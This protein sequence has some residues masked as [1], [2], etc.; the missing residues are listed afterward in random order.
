M[1]FLAVAIFLVTLA[2]VVFRPG[3]IGIWAVGGAAIALATGVVSLANVGTVWSLVWNATF[4]F[5][6]L[7]LLSLVLDRAG[8]FKA[9]AVALVRNSNGSGR[10]LFLYLVAGCALVAAIFANDGA[11]LILT[12][13]VIEILTALEVPNAAELALVL[14][15]GF[16]A[17][18]T[19]LPLITSNLVN[20]IAANYSHI[21]Y[22]S[23]AAVMIPVDLVAAASSFIVLWLVFGKA[24]PK[25]LDVSRTPRPLS[26]VGDMLTFKAG[27]AAIPVLLAGYFV[28]D[29]FGIPLSVT[30]SVVTVGIGAI[31]LRSSMLSN[32]GKWKSLLA[33]LLREAPWQ[34]VIFSV[35]MYLVVYGL[36]NQGLAHL[37]GRG[38]TA[39]TSHGQLAG[40]L[41]AGFGSAFASSIMNNLPSV[42]V[43]SLSIT[44]AHVGKVLSTRLAYANI[45][46]C[47]L[48]PKFTPIGSLATLLWLHVLAKRSIDVSWRTYMSYGAVLT[49][50]VLTVVLLALYGVVVI[51]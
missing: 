19:S 45:I 9:I 28:G 23:Y 44:A 32:G 7:I 35:G 37:L 13:V 41:A 1:L 26:Q 33:E 34:I 30:T 31:Y 20:I 29:R 2:L 47:D 46:G 24:I 25:E 36:K 49:V 4:T 6:G 5:V 39:A 18:T 43:G 48:G 40:I 21:G 42:L 15:I 51:T 8:F 22:A 10:R 3:A 27:I 17:D 14:S 16:V 50:P 11:A 12:P 38:L